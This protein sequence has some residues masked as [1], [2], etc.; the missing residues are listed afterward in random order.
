[1]GSVVVL[2]EEGANIDMEEM[3]EFEVCEEVMAV[4]KIN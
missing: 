1:M 4:L 2:K 3:E